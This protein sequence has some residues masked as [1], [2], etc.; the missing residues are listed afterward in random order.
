MACNMNPNEWILSS[1]T[2]VSSKTIWAVMMGVA[3]APGQRCGFASRTLDLTYDI[4]FDPAD[5]GRCHRLLKLFPDWRSGI[6]R[7]GEIF[8]KWKPMADRWDEL[9]RLYEEERPSGKCP[10]L[11]DLMKTLREEG[12]L[13]EGWT[14]TSSSSWEFKGNER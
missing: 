5:F 4:P 6:A 9:E 2:G 11:Y 8:P 1:D 7:M 13:L 3:I 10:K 12:M 14:K